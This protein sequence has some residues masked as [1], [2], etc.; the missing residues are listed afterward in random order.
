MALEFTYQQASCVLLTDEYVRGIATDPALVAAVDAPRTQ[1]VE[2][3]EVEAAVFGTL[4]I[5]NSEQPSGQPANVSLVE[6][7]D[8]SLSRLAR[9]SRIAFNLALAKQPAVAVGINFQAT[10][11]LSDDDR[12]ALLSRLFRPSIVGRGTDSE[13]TLT[14]GGIKLIYD[15]KPWTVTVVIER[16]PQ[17]G[18]LVVCGA[19]FNIN[20]PKK[21]QVALVREVDK[22]RAWFE[23]EVSEIIGGDENA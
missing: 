5:V 3:P 20:R 1:F 11:G 13:R 18:T 17:K 4:Q 15:M 19:N 7:G 6:M 12:D 8:E 22:L 16:D 21:N 10:V 2:T 23:N 14:G 9:A